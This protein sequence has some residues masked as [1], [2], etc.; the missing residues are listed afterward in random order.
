MSLSIDRLR[1]H[2]DIAVSNLDFISWRRDNH[3]DDVPSFED[4]LI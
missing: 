4:A 1:D 2:R 3:S